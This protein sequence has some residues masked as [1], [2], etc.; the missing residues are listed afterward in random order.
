MSGLPL[1]ATGTR[2]IDWMVRGTDGSPA[3][4][5]PPHA[6][7]WHQARGRRQA[8]CTRAPPPR[9]DDVPGPAEQVQLAVGVQPGQVTGADPAVDEHVGGLGRVVPVGGGLRRGTDEELAHRARRHVGA[10]GADDR[11]VDGGRRRPTE[12]SAAGD[13]CISAGAT[14]LIMPV[15]V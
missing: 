9:C 13:A 4:A 12:A 14:M 3:P 8:P 11:T 2:S 6:A 7:A 1:V 15:S 10:V 5:P